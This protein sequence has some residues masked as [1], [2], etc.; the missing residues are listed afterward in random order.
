M[1]GAV[2]CRAK[3]RW[4]YRNYSAAGSGQQYEAMQRLVAA[5]LGKA[6][7]AANEMTYFHATL[8]L[9]GCGP[10]WR[11]HQARDGGLIVYAPYHAV[12]VAAFTTLL[13]CDAISALGGASSSLRGNSI[14]RAFA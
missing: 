6:G 3:N 12:Y 4:S 2:R 8:R 1:L 5:G 9:Q 7:R 11:W 10:R 14:L 13:Q